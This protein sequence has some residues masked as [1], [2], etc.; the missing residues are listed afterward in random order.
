MPY[1]SVSLSLILALCFLFSSFLAQL[2]YDALWQE[3]FVL[4]ASVHRFVLP[5]PIVKH[6]AFGFQNILAD[7]YWVTA[8]QDFNKWDKFDF[9]YPEYFRIISTLDP[10]FEYPYI[11]AALTLPS[12]QNPASFEWLALVAEQG[13]VAVPHSWQI[14]YY[15]GVEFHA[16]AKSYERAVHYLGLAAAIPGSPEITREAYALFLLHTTTDY[17]KSR[18][19]FVAIYKTADNDETRS[20]ARER[21]TL[22]D[23]LEA[24]DQGS[25]VYKEK[26]HQ[27]P[28]SIEELSSVGLVVIPAEIVRH[29]PINIDKLTGKASLALSSRQY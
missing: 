16:V 12:K 14:P 21:I 18:A 2:R 23:L 25:V 9:Y 6:F 19:L 10:K 27:Y 13:I 17:Q 22:L 1:S 7:Y 3:H 26:Y 20:V 15:T 11:F 29:Y 28:T 24:V 5:A 8:V 4:Q